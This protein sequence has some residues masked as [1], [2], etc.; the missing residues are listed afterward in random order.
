MKKYDKEIYHVHTIRCGHAAGSDRELIEACISLGAKAVTFTDHAPFPGDPFEH[1]MNCSELEEYISTFEKLKK[2]YADRIAVHTGLEIEFFPQYMAYY[3]YLNSISEL[4]AGLLLGQ[5]MYY[6]DGRYSFSFEK[7]ELSAEEYLELGRLTALGAQTGMFRRIAH[8]DRAFRRIYTWTE[9]C[10][11]VSEEI[12][13]AAIRMKLPIEENIESIHKEKYRREFWY[14]AFLHKDIQTYVGADA[15][16]V[17]DIINLDNER[18]WY[19]Q[20]IE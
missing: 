4:D 19:G 8:P 15:H 12:I 6:K 1:R 3:K 2:E 13:D 9:S 17:E 18:I 20:Y 16:S 11:D 7:K 14:L 10:T 5:H